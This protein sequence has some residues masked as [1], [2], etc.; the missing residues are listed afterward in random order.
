MSVDC[1]FCKIVEGS[2]PA[3]KIYEDEKTVVFLDILPMSVGHAIVVPKTHSENLLEANPTDVSAVLATMQRIAPAFGSALGADAMNIGINCG[4][5]AGQTI[6]HSHA[7][8]IPRVT[9]TPR[10]FEHMTVTQEELA[11]TAEKLRAKM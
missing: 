9:G 7:H 5:A 1:L 11:A 3:H 6:F 2:I 10:S 8:M 4:A